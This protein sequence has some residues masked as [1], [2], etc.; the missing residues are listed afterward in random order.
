MRHY[1]INLTLQISLILFF[2]SP[3]YGLWWDSSLVTIDG[4]EYNSEDFKRW[5]TFWNDE[6]LPLPETADPYVDWLL[7]AREGKRMEFD[8]DPSFQRR[9]G[10]FLKVR[11]LLSFQKELSDKVVINDSDLRP[12]YEKMYTPI[13]LLE[14][15]QYDTQ[16]QAKAAVQQISE[17]TLTAADLRDKTPESGGP[18]YVFEDWHRPVSINPA[19]ADIFRPLHVGQCSEAYPFEDHYVFYCVK[20]MKDGGP[21]DFAKVK[22]QIYRKVFDEKERERMKDLLESLRTKYEV[23]VDQERIDNLSL[24]AADDTY[25]DEPVITTNRQNVSEKV[26]MKILKNDTNFRQSHKRKNREDDDAMKTRILSGIINQNIVEWE[27]LDRK[28]QEREPLK[29]EYEFNINHRLTVEMQRR[30]IAS[31]V[32]VSEAETENYYKQNLARYTQ[33]ERVT[34]NIVKDEGNDAVDAIWQDVLTGTQFSKAVK[35][36]TGKS[37]TKREFPV[38]HL[39]PEVRELLKKMNQG[40]TSQPF[41]SQGQRAILH[42]VDRVPAAQIPY[43]RAEKSIREKLLKEKLNNKR[44]AYVA[45]LREGSTIEINESTWKAIQDE[46]GDAE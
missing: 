46:L 44:E 33:P 9:T 43:E 37:E 26:F 22:P 5:W 42:L 4:V 14:R 11:S 2:I 45:Q 25:S 32:D 29:W 39:L 41:V 1:L 10:V 16:D 8:T 17:G 24:S 28:Y 7:L 38:D 36:H 21:E 13:W 15:F 34:I 19:W 12:L 30:I 3:V 20:E 18:R 23:N 6:D 31:D 40:E 27:A 35:N